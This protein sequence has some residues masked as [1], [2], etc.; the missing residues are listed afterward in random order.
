MNNLLSDKTL[1]R[2]AVRE[3]E[4]RL[5]AISG[6]V[7]IMEVCGTHTMAIASSGLRRL[8]PK[9]IKLLS[10]PGCPVCVTAAGDI[11]RAVSVAEQP[12]V[13]IA[14]FGDMMKVRGSVRSLEE[15]RAS[16]ADVRIV[17]SPLDALAIALAEPSKE[18]V[19]L[20]VGFETTAPAVASTVLKADAGA[21]K[22]FSVISLFKLVPPALRILLSDPAQNIN[23]FILPGHVSAIIGMK[24]YKFIA[25]EFHIPAVITGFE[26]L[27]ILR[28]LNLLLEL[29]AKKEAHIENEYSRTVRPE[30]NPAA[31]QA[32]DRVFEA[33]PAHWRAIGEIP[34]SGLC[35]HEKYSGFDAFKKFAVPYKDAPEPAGCLCGNILMGRAT[36]PDCPLF[37]KAC[38]PSAAIGPCMVSSEGACAAWYK[39]GE[40]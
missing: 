32:M 38:T 20:G 17:Y 4:S 13:I 25:D 2:G 39:Y 10:G 19:F 7:N 18:V 11:D 22:N 8:F 33:C 21:L 5:S 28:T 15:R 3:M 12:G 30:G 27:D 34:L 37:G 26:P 9:G 40:Q 23:G 35:F 31:L 16:G 6:P 24:P 14:T 36:P 29:L 1:V